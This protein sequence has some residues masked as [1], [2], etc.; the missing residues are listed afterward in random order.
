MAAGTLDP[1]RST[2]TALRPDYP[3][4][5]LRGTHICPPGPGTLPQQTGPSRGPGFSLEPLVLPPRLGLWD[6][7]TLSPP[8]KGL[9]GSQPAGPPRLKPP[10][11]NPEHWLLLESLKHILHISTDAP[12]RR[13]CDA[14][15]GKGEAVFPLAL[16]LPWG[17]VIRWILLQLRAGAHIPSGDTG[18]QGL[19][20]CGGWGGGLRVYG[21]RRGC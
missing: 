13:V 9:W 11:C 12:R 18:P 5:P 10:T 19:R 15:S 14:L 2:G 1:E 7:C 17:S 16:P 21:M 4:L 20:L 3:R 6:I 8:P